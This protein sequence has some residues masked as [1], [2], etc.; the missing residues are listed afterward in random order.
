MTH[1]KI[2]THVHIHTWETGWR[3]MYT[4]KTWTAKRHDVISGYSCQP[5]LKIRT[6]GARKRHA[7]DHNSCIFTSR[8][9]TLVRRWVSWWLP[10]S[11]SGVPLSCSWLYRYPKTPFLEATRWVVGGGWRTRGRSR[12]LLCA[13]HM[14]LCVSFFNSHNCYRRFAAGAAFFVDFGVYFTDCRPRLF[15]LSLSEVVCRNNSGSGLPPVSSWT[16]RPLSWIAA[17]T[18]GIHH[19]W[20][21]FGEAFMTRV[22]FAAAAA[23]KPRHLHPCE[24]MSETQ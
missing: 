9:S 17:W 19:I 3:K 6:E 21:Q 18:I 10:A 1:V 20:F 2:Y 7:S 15:I 23:E 14:F 11:S 12:V 4:S 8:M 13:F 22:L 16:W 5:P 24:P